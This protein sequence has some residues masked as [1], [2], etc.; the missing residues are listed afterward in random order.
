MCGI[1]K[2][3]VHQLPNALLNAMQLLKQLNTPTV[4]LLELFLV[5]FA[6]MLILP[7]HT[8]MHISFAKHSL[9]IIQAVT[10]KV[11]HSINVLDSCKAVCTL[12]YNTHH[13]LFCREHLGMS[14]YVHLFGS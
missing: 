10:A 14:N 13:Q 8:A 9:V 2:Q 7:W 3:L 11:A 4:K 1:A 5:M 6:N 12:I